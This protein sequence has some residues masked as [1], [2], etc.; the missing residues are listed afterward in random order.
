MSRLL[1]ETE[2]LCYV[3]TAS[4]QGPGKRCNIQVTLPGCVQLQEHTT[5]FSINPFGFSIQGIKQELNVAAVL[6]CLYPGSSE[7]SFQTRTWDTLSGGIFVT[8]AVRMNLEEFM[9]EPN[10]QCLL[11]TPTVLIRRAP[12]PELNMRLKNTHNVRYE[13][14]PMAARP[15]TFR[16]DKL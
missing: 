15:K 2:S 4:H 16:T 13:A 8:K 1:C 7:H 12:T 14:L 11:H 9:K 10:Y 6:V 3:S 5:H